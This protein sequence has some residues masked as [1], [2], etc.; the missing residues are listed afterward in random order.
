[1]NDTVDTPSSFEANEPDSE[2]SDMFDHK[3]AEPSEETK[4]KVP[5]MIEDDQPKNILHPEIDGSSA[6]DEGHFNDKWAKQTADYNKQNQD[7]SAE[8]EAKKSKDL[9]AFDK[10]DLEKEWSDRLGQSKDK[11]WER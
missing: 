10:A 1:M 11:G 9:D 4:V 2:I 3:A 7:I 8:F 6:V 5:E